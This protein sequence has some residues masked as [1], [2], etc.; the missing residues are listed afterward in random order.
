LKVVNGRGSRSWAL[1]EEEMAEKLKRMGL[2]KEVL[3]KTS[4]ITLPNVIDSVRTADDK[5]KCKVSWEKKKRD[6]TVEVMTLSDSQL[7][8]LEREYI[9]KSDG[10]LVV[11]P[12]ADNRPAAGLFEIKMFDAVPAAIEPLPTW[13]T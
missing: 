9:K 11:V 2:P 7:A 1:P 12:E 3:W 8:I 13:L 4:L 6:G 5:P 10:K